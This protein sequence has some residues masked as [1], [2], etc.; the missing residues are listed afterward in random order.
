[1]HK[2]VVM[3]TQDRSAGVKGSLK[4]LGL[5]PVKGKEVLIKPNFNTADIAP[6]STHNDTLA[7]LIDEI[8]EMGA[9]DISLGERSFPETKAVMTQKGVLSLLEQ[10]QVRLLDFDQLA[11]RD[12]VKCKPEGTLWKDGFRVARPILEAECLVATCC[13]KT[14]QFG[15]VF[16]MALKLAVGVVPTVRHGYDYMSELHQSNFQQELIADINAAFAPDIVVLDGIDAFVDQGPATGKRAKG[17]L[18][19]ASSDRVAIDAT[20]VAMLKHLGS[21]EAI[22]KPAIFAQRQLARAAEL[23]LGAKSAA[24]IELVAADEASTTLRDALEAIL[25]TA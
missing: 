21:N 9:S 19:L 2:V 14:H 11:D 7:A 20:G 17:N 18:F 12:W 10:K 22:M 24:D 15:G 4:A 8:W 16:T 3:Q 1:M 13:L 25:K 23:G 5:N 6:G